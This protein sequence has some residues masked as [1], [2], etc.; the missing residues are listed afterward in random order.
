MFA[1]SENPYASPAL[2]ETPDA[3]PPKVEVLETEEERI[4]RL[5]LSVETS[6]R[7][8][9]AVGYILAGVCG[10]IVASAGVTAIKE[11]LRVPNDFES[12]IVMVLWGLPAAAFFVEGRALRKLN[13]LAGNILA[14]AACLLI[15]VIL[16]VILW[17]GAMP[18]LIAV[19]FAAYPV[20][21]VRGRKGRMVF[22][23]EYVRIRQQTP[24]MVYRPQ[25]VQ[26]TSRDMLLMLLVI[27]GATIFMLL[28]RWLR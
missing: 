13:R 3:P 10:A 14:I 1:E 25:A 18:L 27:A 5:H 19:P 16:G 21:L 28:V 15:V 11:F 23:D 2:V 17:A 6:I 22:S 9:G 7:T 12:L 26:W 8:L 4:R 20:F 24:Y